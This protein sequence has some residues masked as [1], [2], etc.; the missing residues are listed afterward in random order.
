MLPSASVATAS[1]PT[2][3][4]ETKQQA[5]D[6]LSKSGNP[7]DAFA[8]YN[9]LR[10]CVDARK[11]DLLRAAREAEGLKNQ[12][13]PSDQACGDLSPGQ[14]TSRLQLLERAAEAG[15]QG[16]AAAFAD[17]GPGGFGYG[18]PRQPGDA[19]D[20][21][22]QQAMSHYI[23]IGAQHRDLWSLEAMTSK[24]EMSPP[25][26]IPDYAAALKYLDEANEVSRQQTGSDLRG[27][28]NEKTRLQY[29]LRQQQKKP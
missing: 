6:R 10:L 15:V 18:V 14:I 7:V 19:E 3:T 22:F 20:A 24:S 26:G 2:S 5:V 28:I 17:E 8:A 16:A 29:L 11:S 12:F 27:Y 4:V 9:I 1:A 21:S 23:E 13:P 25:S